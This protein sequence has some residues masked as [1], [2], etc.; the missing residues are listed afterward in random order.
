MD[1]VL[2]LAEAAFEHGERIEAGDGDYFRLADVSGAELWLRSNADKEIILLSPHFRGQT[3]MTVGLENAIT[4]PE[5]HTDGFRAWAGVE[6]EAEPLHGDYP[7]VFNCPDFHTVGKLELPKAEQ[8]QVACFADQLQAF[9][10]EEAFREGTKQP[11]GLGF[12]AESFIPVGLF[13]EQEGPRDPYT[14]PLAIVN[15][16]LLDQATKMNSMTDEAFWWGRV[17]TLGGELDMV[18]TPGTI[19]GRPKTGGLVSALGWVSGTLL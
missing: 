4:D 9:D 12:S 19:K 3:K 17:R 6:N 5:D 14:L 8:V 1:E 10:D 11:N 16:T 15:G 13:E 18:A 2:R 7:F